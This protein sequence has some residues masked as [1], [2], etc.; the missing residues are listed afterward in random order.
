MCLTFSLSLLLAM[1]PRH[2]GEF[3]LS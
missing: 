3:L 1:L 2:T